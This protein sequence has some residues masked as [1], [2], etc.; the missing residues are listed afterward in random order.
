[1]I[2]RYNP[3]VSLSKI[4]HAIGVAS[5]IFVSSQS[6]LAGPAGER[7]TQGNA[8]VSRS[9]ST[10]RI[11]QASDKAVINWQQFNIGRGER[12]DF[13]QPSSSSVTL[14]RVTG[15]SISDIQGQL[16]ANGHIFL[17][18]P[19]G[20]VLGK[21]ATIDVAGLVASTSDISDSNFM[22]G[23]FE[24]DGNGS[25]TIVNQG[26]ISVKQGGLVALVAPTVR[27][28]GVIQARL[29]RV[30]L[31]SGDRFTLDLYGDGLIK[32]A[33][34]E[35][36]ANRLVEHSGTINADGGKVLISAET[37][38]AA[39]DSVVNMSGVVQARAVAGRAGEIRLIGGQVNTGGTLD[40]SASSGDGGT[41]D[42]L[43]N[44]IAVNGLVTA[45]GSNNGGE[46]HI[47]GDYQG[48][49]S[50]QRAA[51]T[52][53]GRNAVIS[54]DAGQV[55]KGGRLI[56][57]SDQ[58]TQV[59]G[60]LSARG[61]SRSGD[62]GFVETSSAGKL[63]F[64]SSVDVSAQNG[65]PGSWLID[66]EDI[67]IDRV[68]A[69]AIEDSLNGGSSVI[70]QTS[71]TGA[72]NG[73]ISVDASITKTSG[74]DA[75]LSL[76]AHNDIHVNAPISSTS[77]K[78]DVNLQAVNAVN[79]NSNIDTNGGGVYV[80]KWQI[81]PAELADNSQSISSGSDSGPGSEQTADKPVPIVEILPL[82]DSVSHQ[83]SALAQ[84]E[85]TPIVNAEQPATAADKPLV[86][87]VAALETASPVASAGADSLT[88]NVDQNAEVATN[89]GDIVLLAGSEGDVTIEGNLNTSSTAEQGGTVMASGQTVTVAGTAQITTS[90]TA[91]TATGDA[92]GSV[93]LGVDATQAGQPL[94]ETVVI[95]QGAQIV[96]DAIGQGNAGDVF[97]RS[98][99]STGFHGHINGQGAAD[100]NGAAVVIS[101]EGDLDL[102]GTINVQSN[103]A[104]GH[105]G[106][107]IAIAANELA[108]HGDATD[109]NTLNQLRIEQLQQF[110]D[111]DLTVQTQ[112][113]LTFRDMDGSAGLAQQRRSSRSSAGRIAAFN[114]QSGD[115]VFV[116]D[117]V[118]AADS[119]GVLL[120]AGAGQITNASVVTQGG[121]LAMLAEGDISVRDISTNGGNFTARSENGGFSS[122]RDTVIDLTSSEDVL[123]EDAG[124]SETYQEITSGVLTIDANSIVLREGQ[125]QIGAI[126]NDIDLTVELEGEVDGTFAFPYVDLIPAFGDGPP[127][128]FTLVIES[129][130]FGQVYDEAYS[131]DRPF[132]GVEDALDLLGDNLNCNN[133]SDPDP[134]V[135]SDNFDT[136]MNEGRRILEGIG[137]DMNI[138]PNEAVLTNGDAITVS[139]P[140]GGPADIPDIPQISAPPA[141]TGDVVNRPVVQPPVTEPPVVTPPVTQPPV[142]TMPETT[143]GAGPGVVSGDSNP[144]VD[145]DN[146]ADVAEF[147]PEDER[148]VADPV[149]STSTPDEGGEEIAN[150]D[151]GNNDHFRWLQSG[152]RSAAELANMGR[153]D[154]T[155][156]A[157]VFRNCF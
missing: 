38:K 55:G 132:N 151:C 82:E 37:A 32:L 1:M 101:S 81:S 2:E 116:G 8:S 22:A 20:V 99:N 112:R 70:V 100:G 39:V 106:G 29:G 118:L 66:P 33:V 92:S 154:D 14:N 152:I 130:R 9:G 16:N 124:V 153:S 131:G 60:A 77:G 40:A 41:I 115:I 3:V 114:S 139:L 146:I 107:S 46:I 64:T 43:G 36:L 25:G 86:V 30:A 26:N 157:D 93:V 143:P 51:T 74:G 10:T 28:S 138:L 102:T 85:T 105:N 140:L 89:G 67:T 68:H 7:V 47:G 45:S 119:G 136:V 76:L 125:S 78:L 80:S 142:V 144:I 44:T 35:Q 90:G 134:D 49:G 145:I 104:S 27:N 6:A 57:W 53:I 11:D 148:R 42:I 71:E 96:T 88:I 94:A 31:V 52:D 98:S 12:V 95:E 18:N 156:S 108:I 123:V 48:K 155:N 59:D 83:Q 23:R 137:L 126:S 103:S 54:A 149:E 128:S 129:D 56:V 150:N 50:R 19:N 122:A 117:A 15:G 75:A 73:D 133:C 34:D 127:M 13:N 5:L 79:I 135:E 24:F 65:K 110:G 97:V 111:V 21:T 61:G 109:T 58:R 62:G 147:G 121:D 63:D 141:P 69:D 72:G 17:I 4:T 120:E 84:I 87:P 91:A 113:N